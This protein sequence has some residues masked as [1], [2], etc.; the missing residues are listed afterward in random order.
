MSQ[1]NP[2]QDL[3]ILVVSCDKYADCWEPF[4]LCLEK[5]WPDCPYPVYLATETKEAPENTVYQKVLHST[6][7][8]W[9]GR[10]REVCEQIHES[11]VFI[12]LE[13]HWIADTIDSDSISNVFQLI[14][15]TPEI[16]VIYLDYPVKNDPIWPENSQYYVIPAGS[17]YRLSAG[18]SIWRKSFLQ[19]ACAEDADAWNFERVKSFS[20]TT[21]SH[22]ALTCIQSLYHR[23]HPAGA[24][25]R[26]KWQSF[27]PSFAKDNSMAIDF[28]KR[29]T[30][31]FM[32]NFKIA[33]KSFIFNLNPSLI[34]KVQNWL[35]H[36][37][38]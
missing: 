19:S 15:S 28:S 21:Y 36:L 10:L 13:D 8:S 12:T 24:V 23:I 3:C 25:Q 2:S 14:Q 6:N 26:G 27:V 4:S 20:P 35:Y 9:T 7:P 18:P 22:T 33:V 32:D 1:I 5:F 17:A 34:V 30:M 16:G 38:K 37:Q 29:E 31:S 11:F